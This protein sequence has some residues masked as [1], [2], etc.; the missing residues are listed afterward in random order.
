MH[1]LAALVAV[2]V[3][4]GT[5]NVNKLILQ[6]TQ[7]GGG[8][9]LFHRQDGVGV[10]NTVTMDL[11]GRKGYPSE[12]L[13]A[14]RLQVNYAAQGKTL[15]L[16]NEVVTYKPGGAQQ[17]MRE[18]VHHANTCPT[19][20]IVTG[21]AGVPPLRFTITRIS[22]SK[23]LKGYLAVRIR[24]RGTVKLNVN[25]QL[26]KRK[27]DQTSYAVYQRL[28]NVLSGTYSYGPNT[29]AQLAFELHAAEQ[30]AQNLRRGHNVGSP[31]A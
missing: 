7:V 4:T 22:D 10:K 21:E 24:V 18:V 13:R 25:G 1:V 2:V 29:A 3:S 27:V 12:K 16:S 20:P 15:G 23:L 8:Y 19:T 9:Q 5:P 28:G 30:S 14:T 26:Q 11:C 31:T 17:A 6:P